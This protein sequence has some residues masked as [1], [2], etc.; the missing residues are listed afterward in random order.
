MLVISEEVKSYFAELINPLVTAEQLKNSL[1]AFQ[2][3]VL[4]KIDTLEKKLVE[5]EAIID[6]NSS[7]IARLDSE[8][9]IARNAIDLLSIKEDDT[10][11]YT[12]RYS[13]RINGLPVSDN[14]NVMDTVKNCYEELNIDFDR[15]DFD[16][17]HRTGKPTL[18]PVKKV[19]TQPVLVKYRHWNARLK[20]YKARPKFQKTSGTQKPVD[21]KFTVSTDL[22]T[23]RYKLLKYARETISKS[24]KAVKFAF[25]DVNCSLGLAFTNGTLGFFNTKD[26]LHKLLGLDVN[27]PEV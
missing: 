27:D 9:K 23:R 21:R 15:D 26:T 19:V 8:L 18:D 17:A 11:Q 4:E 10:E 22:T 3:K 14:E 7:T 25:C 13:L 20:L 12:R 5:K 1:T 24:G 6:K 2:D 16:R